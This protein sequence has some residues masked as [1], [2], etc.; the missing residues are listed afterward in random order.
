MDAAPGGPSRSKEKAQQ[1][2]VLI[3]TRPLESILGNFALIK[4]RIFSHKRLPVGYVRP[5]TADFC[6]DRLRGWNVG[7]ARFLL[8]AQN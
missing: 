5:T 1:P 3:K 7:T 8:S 2:V 6:T 4:N